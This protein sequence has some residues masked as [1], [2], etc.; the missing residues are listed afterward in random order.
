[1]QRPR[2]LSQ[3]RRDSYPT[4]GGIQ[5]INSRTTGHCSY[6]N[7]GL[8]LLFHFTH[9]IPRFVRYDM[10]PAAS[11]FIAVKLSCIS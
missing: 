11:S 9:L 5:T 1:M 7:K 4:K 6:S 10:V 2:E 3:H 8:R